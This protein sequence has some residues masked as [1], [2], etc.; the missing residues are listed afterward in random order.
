MRKRKA[1]RHTPGSSNIYIGIF[2]YR[3]LESGYKCPLY[4]S[5]RISSSVYRLKGELSKDIYLHV[6]YI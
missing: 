2:T 1:L 3:Y 4:K 5:L 6:V